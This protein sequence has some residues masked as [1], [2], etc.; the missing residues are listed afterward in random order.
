MSRKIDVYNIQELKEEFPDAYDKAYEEFKRDISDDPY[1]PWQEEIMDSLKSTFKH[2]GVTLQDW[3]IGTYS[4]SYVEFSIPTYWSELAEEDMLVD[5]YEAQLAVDWLKDAYGISKADR[6]KYTNHLGKDAY[7]WD[8]KKLD[9]TDWSCEFTG[10]CADHDFLDSLFE[11]VACDGMNLKDAFS[12]LADE[13]RKL[14]ENEYE[15]QQSE[16]Y[17]LEEASNNGY[18]YTEEGDKI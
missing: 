9:G 2:A 15:Y 4:P 12:N 18:E 7:R 10:Y 8:F 1:L 11:C 6:V 13:A 5:D 3:S 14:F 16:E 17:F